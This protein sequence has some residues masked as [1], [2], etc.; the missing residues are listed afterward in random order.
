M[1]ITA[2]SD[3]HGSLEAL[4]SS[5]SLLSDLAS[6]DLVLIAGDITNFQGKTQT[7][8]VITAIRRHNPNIFAVPGNCDTAAVD[9][10][11]REQNINLHC[12]TRKHADFTLTGVGAHVP[13]SRNDQACSLEEKLQVCL[14]HIAEMSHAE[15]NLIFVAHYPARHTAVDSI[16]DNHHGGS[17]NIRD[18]IEQAQPLLALSGHI[19]DAP[20]T[21]H[22]GRT[23]LVNPGSL[24]DGSYAQIRIEHERVR[25]HIGCIKKRWREHF[26][27][28]IT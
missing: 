24:R 1:L 22:I 2:L 13:C 4:N 26:G 20:G 8:E 11:L 18:F 14:D 19:H 21:D 23:T 28:G 6:S 12:Q 3:I 7:A 27:Y 10:Y 15:N 16:G 17:W 9:E 25:V 5:K